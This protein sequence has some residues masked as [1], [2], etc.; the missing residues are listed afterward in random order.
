M[1]CTDVI[2]QELAVLETAPALKEAA[3]AVSR[4]Q[5]AMWDKVRSET[6]RH[7]IRW[8]LLSVTE[9]LGTPSA[10]RRATRRQ[11]AY[12]LV[13][14]LEPLAAL[15]VRPDDYRHAREE[16]YLIERL[17]EQ[18]VEKLRLVR[19]YYPLGA[20]AEP[21]PVRPNYL[22]TEA[23]DL[24]VSH[25]VRTIIRQTMR[26]K[27]MATAIYGAMTLP[28]EG[29]R[30]SKDDPF[31]AVAKQFMPRFRQNAMEIAV[32]WR[33]VAQRHGWS[34]VF[35]MQGATDMEC[36]A[37]TIVQA[38][39]IEAKIFGV[40]LP[41]QI[42]LN[43]LA[44]LTQISRAGLEVSLKDITSAINHEDGEPYLRRMLER[45]TSRSLP[46]ES[47]LV[48]LAALHLPVPG[49]RLPI[50]AANGSCIGS[51]RSRQEMLSVRS[52]LAGE[53][54]RLPGECLNRLMAHMTGDRFTSDGLDALL[55]LSL[56][57]VIGLSRVRFEPELEVL[58]RGLANIDTTGRVAKWLDGT[59]LPSDIDEMCIVLADA[60]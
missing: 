53:L 49:E 27:F 9:F 45:I 1:L 59:R 25:A 42:D 35:E 43:F 6:G 30:R 24:M 57:L 19:S 48:M 18:L 8:D 16:A 2:Q 41:E 23:A 34:D 51:C 15:E 47:D 11:L 56:E 29:A 55:R 37:I 58:E 44:L 52:I 60:L 39:R 13:E 14:V 21:S 10:A 28:A 4:I 12:G 46:L 54:Q 7:S 32:A 17:T 40:Y 3:L 26:N 31:A 5:K 33:K 22:L 50:Q 36:A 38:M 20:D